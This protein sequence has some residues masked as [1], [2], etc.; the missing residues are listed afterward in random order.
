[1]IKYVMTAAAL[2]S[3]STS[4]QTKRMYR[5][6]GN[7]LGQSRR[8]Q[9]GVSEKYLDRARRILGLCERHHAIQKGDRLLEVGTGWVHWEAT[10]LR[11][12]YDVEITLFDVWDN[13]QLGAYKHYCGQ[14]ERAID[15]ELDIDP[16]QHERAHNLLRGISKAN[17]FDEIYDLLGFRYVINPSGTLEQF[18]DDTF[19]VIFSCN[20]LEHIE[21]GILPGYIQDFHR[22]LKPGGHSVHQI[23][24]GDHLAYY[25]KK[26][27]LK[28]YLRYSN[29]SWKWYFENDVQYFNRVQRPEWLN[30]F[31][32]AGFEVVE[33][34]SIFADIG[35]IKV[36][37]S[38][39]H[40]CKQDL[41]CITMRVVH[42]KPN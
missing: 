25:D 28:N 41:H 23:D 20:V 26:A 6:L 33:E 22:I 16:N 31:S 38:Y 13:R 19:T 10:I 11:L 37:K 2:K 1:M 30:I 42:G 17:S 21:R 18:Q 35:T 24:L 39:E 5:L 32:R 4:T 14:L 3:F 12:F 15:R 29:K 7:R 8:I 40:L 34:E 27:S 36:H 9:Y